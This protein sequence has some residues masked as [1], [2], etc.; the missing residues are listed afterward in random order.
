[1]GRYPDQT[2]DL[3]KAVRAARKYPGGNGKVGA[4][5]GSSGGSHAVYLAATGMAGDDRLDGAVALS[6]AFDFTDPASLRYGNFRRAV[7]NYCGSSNPEDLRKASP[8]TYIDATISPLYVIA[9]DHETM[10]PQQLPDLVEKLNEVG[11]KNFKQ[12]L[13]TNSEE[14]A[15][16]YWP[17]VRETVLDFLKV[18]L[19][20]PAPA[21]VSSATASPGNSPASP[22]Q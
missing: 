5:G 8:I 19:G 17:E 15:F 2:N 7:E 13:R 20:A 9:S 10:A 6:G 14:H 1:M 11:A 22:R 4:I 21:P 16:A 18:E 3:K 12:R